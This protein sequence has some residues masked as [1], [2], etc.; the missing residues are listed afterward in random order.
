M[1][2]FKTNINSKL[3]CIFIYS[4]VWTKGT[5][6]NR[7]RSFRVSSWTCFFLKYLLTALLLKKI[8][9]LLECGKDLMK[10]RKNNTVSPWM[11][12]WWTRK[13]LERC[14]KLVGRTNQ[15]TIK[16]GNTSHEGI[17]NICK[18]QLKR[19]RGQS[20]TRFFWRSSKVKAFKKTTR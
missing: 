4:F 2:Y 17:W 20:I 14:N 9:A 8:E 7:N 11:E 15:S 1:Y 5:I 6:Q 19:G 13:N 18:G 12:S 16:W 3:I 10:T